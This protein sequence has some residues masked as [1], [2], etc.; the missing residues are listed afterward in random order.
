MVFSFFKWLIQEWH[1]AELHSYSPFPFGIMSNGLSGTSTF[2]LLLFPFSDSASY[3]YF[4][5]FSKSFN[6]L[7]VL[8]YPFFFL[9][10][11]PSMLI[12]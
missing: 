8:K 5:V 2:L 11:I 10:H 7:F 6:I 3:V 12:A 4:Q 1:I 9:F